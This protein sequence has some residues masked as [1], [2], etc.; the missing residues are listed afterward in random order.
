MHI[1]AA[2]CNFR[3]LYHLL[4]S[5]LACTPCPFCSQVVRSTHPPELG[6]QNVSAYPAPSYITPDAARE[7]PPKRALGP[8]AFH[9]FRVVGKPLGG[10]GLSSKGMKEWAEHVLNTPGRDYVMSH[11]RPGSAQQPAVRQQT[12]QMSSTEGGSS[13]SARCGCWG[14]KDEIEIATTLRVLVL[15]HWGVS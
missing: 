13:V 6:P 12:V 10:Q 7:A 3:N 1:T 9:Q 5:S 4:T 15:R 8:G 14:L 11:R 2:V